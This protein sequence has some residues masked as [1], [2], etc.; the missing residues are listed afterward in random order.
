MA[1]LAIDQGTSATKAMVVGDGGDVLGFAE[2]GV[3]PRYLGD[4]KVEQ[5][6]EELWNSVVVA[7]RQALEGSPQ[8][9]T[10]VGFANQGET[11]LAWDPSDGTVRSTALSWQDRRGQVICRELAQHAERL[12]EVTGLPLDPYFAAPK[13]TWLAR[14]VDAPDAAIT[15]SDAWLLWRMTGAFVTDAATASRTMLLDL[16]SAQ[17]SPEALEIFAVGDRPQPTVVDCAEPVGTTSAFGTATPLPVTGL[18]VDQQAALFAER[19]FEPGEMK[20]TY[21]TGAF[22][23]A[24]LGPRPAI[25]HTGLVT[26]VAWRVGDRLDY[27]LDGQVYSVGSTISWLERLGIIDEPA[28]LDRLAQPDGSD[29]GSEAEAFVPALAG[30][31]APYW[32]D[33][34]RGALT[35]LSLSTG[36]AEVVTAV[37]RS[38]AASVARLAGAVRQDTA[39]APATLRADGGLTRSRALMQMQ[40]DLAQVPVEVYPSPHAT[41]LGVGALARLGA[42]HVETLEGAVPPWTPSAVYEPTI[43]GRQAAAVLD[44]FD[45]VVERVALT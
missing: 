21:G 27:C 4:G 45:E 28:D 40:A 6:P 34:A 12:T 35:G 13:M 17:W 10:A 2:V 30:L 38:I 16:R 42:G 5:D 39:I 33:D 18:A 31:A 1:V 11:V 24:N 25:S 36:K 26:C 44:R 8:P 15:T 41:A 37:L 19:C 20:V 23:L 7:G 14:E 32:R 3:N 43:S 9:V 22:L 29:G